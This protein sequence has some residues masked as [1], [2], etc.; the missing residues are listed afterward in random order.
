MILFDFI[1]SLREYRIKWELKENN[2]NNKEKCANY[3]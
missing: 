3:L 1:F 2:K